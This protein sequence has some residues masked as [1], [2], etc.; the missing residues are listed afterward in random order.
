MMSFCFS[1]YEV[2]A[3]IKAL[4]RATNEKGPRERP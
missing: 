2:G 1:F 4:A 3:T